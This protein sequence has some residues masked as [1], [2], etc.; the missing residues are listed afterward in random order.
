MRVENY[1][2]PCLLKKTVSYGK[3]LKHP[4]AAWLGRFISLREPAAIRKAR[5]FSGKWFLRAGFSSW[6][7]EILSSQMRE[8]RLNVPVIFRKILSVESQKP[9]STL[10]V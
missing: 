9:F 7:S 8:S 2:R 1:F 3:P 10:F 5:E 6:A 4:S